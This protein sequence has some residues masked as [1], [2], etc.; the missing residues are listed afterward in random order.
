MFVFFFFSPTRT[1]I[2]VAT[3]H[4]PTDYGLQV[5]HLEGPGA[6]SR[7][8]DQDPQDRAAAEQPP[9]LADE[10]VVPITVARLCRR[11]YILGVFTVV[12]N[13]P[14][15]AYLCGTML[16]TTCL[17]I[18]PRVELYCLCLVRRARLS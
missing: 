11:Y 15:C 2:H 1:Y 17:E 5:P 16:T 6:E 3:E 7:D 18:S 4:G 14:L 13:Q 12:A 8:R 9:A 10:G